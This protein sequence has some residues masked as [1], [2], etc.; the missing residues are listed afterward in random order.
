[1]LELADQQSVADETAFLALCET[2]AWPARTSLSILHSVATAWC[3]MVE[4]ESHPEWSRDDRRR[5]DMMLR[6][7]WDE[8][9]PAREAGEDPSY[10][11]LF[12]ERDPDLARRFEANLIRNNQR[13]P[14][15]VTAF[16]R[17]LLDCMADAPVSSATGGA[18]A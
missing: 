4:E 6:Q 5:A 10:P 14:R 12:A 1:V 18:S 3:N 13:F 8:Q 9:G 11:A 17:M 7:I 15:R 16:G 2:A